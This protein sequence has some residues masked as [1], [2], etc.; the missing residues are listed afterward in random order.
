VA[1][2]GPYLIRAFTD[3]DVALVSAWRARP[4]VRRWW[5]DPDIEPEAE[6]HA[7]PSQALWI[8]EL[9]DHPFAF[10]QDYAVHDWPDHHFAY[11]PLGSRGVDLFIGEPDLLGQGHGSR[12]LRRHVDD[13]FTRG[14]PAMGIDPNPDNAQAIRAFEKAGFTTVTG[15]VDTAWGRAVPMD[16]RAP[17]L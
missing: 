1:A 11:L 4:H 14:V 7:D 3:I 12:L 5:G 6:K 17:G 10:I 2:S 16:R 13:W 8:A 15:P 9:D